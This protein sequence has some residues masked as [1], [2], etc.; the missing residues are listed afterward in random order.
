MKKFILLFLVLFIL[1][2][3]LS[4]FAHDISLPPDLP[5][6]YY[7]VYYDTTKYVLMCTNIPFRKIG[8]ELALD[9]TQTRYWTLTYD[10]STWE[11]IGLDGSLFREVTFTDERISLSSINGPH[12]IVAANYDIIDSDTGE[13]FFSPPLPPSLMEIVAT[14]VQELPLVLLSQVRVILV[15]GILVLSLVI[16][17]GLLRKGL[18]IFFPR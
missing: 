12:T 9:G 15:G 11:S 10:G 7:L 1:V 5:A 18:I 17:V 13:V 6:Q 2:V 8:S 16:L 4:V 14:Q 3:P